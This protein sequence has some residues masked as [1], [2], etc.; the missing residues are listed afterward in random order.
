MEES[1]Q[2][3]INLVIT[4]YAFA[5]TMGIIGISITL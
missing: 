3:T 1:D 2:S 5:I 4:G